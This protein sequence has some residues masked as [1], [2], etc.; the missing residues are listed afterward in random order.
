LQLSPD[1]TRRRSRHP[2]E[3]RRRA[4]AG[5]PAP[6]RGSPTGWRPA[7]LP[8]RTL[9]SASRRTRTPPHRRPSSTTARACRGPPAAWP[10]RA[11]S[12]AAPPPR[13][14]SGRPT[15]RPLAPSP[16]RLLLLWP[17]Q[18]EQAPRGRTLL[19]LPLRRRAA[20]WLRR[21]SHGHARTHAR[22]EGWM[23]PT[24]PRLKGQ[25]RVGKCRGG[26]GKERTGRRKGCFSSVRRGPFCFVW[27]P[28]FS[29]LVW[30]RGI[31]YSL[32]A[33]SRVLYNFFSG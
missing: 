15:P 8:K 16:P 32:R 12:A 20:P 18:E 3:R 31:S 2:R 24:R 13:G 7:A 28:I 10:S 26:V 17:Q 21:W 9:S 23:G 19:L 25:R 22:G 11:A 5:P 29:L 27:R 4:P 6:R 14:P 30:L 33:S 1:R